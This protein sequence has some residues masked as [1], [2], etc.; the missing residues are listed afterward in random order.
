[1]NGPSLRGYARQVPL[2]PGY[3]LDVFQAEF[4]DDWEFRVCDITDPLRIRYV[5]STLSGLLVWRANP[6]DVRNLSRM[7]ERLVLEAVYELEHTCKLHDD[8]YETP[9]LGKAC[10]RAEE[11]RRHETERARVEAKHLAYIRS[12]GYLK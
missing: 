6:H 3:S 5:V 11:K 4:S 7:I 8:C 12:L 10:F 1:M 9:E 2:P